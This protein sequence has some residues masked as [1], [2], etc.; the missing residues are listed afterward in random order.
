[1]TR[2]TGIVVFPDF[3]ILDAAGPISA[4][5]LAGR[6]AGPAAYDLQLLST[7][8][9]SVRSSSGVIVVTAPF[10]EAGWDTLLVAGGSGVREAASCP[11]TLAFVRAARP[12]RIGSVCSGAYVLAE[13][14]LL[15]GRRATTHWSRGEDFRRRYPKLRVEVDAIFVRDGSVWTSA[16][17][18]AGID[19]ALAMIEDDLGEPTARRTA[20][21]LV[22]FHRRPGG[23]SQHSALLDLAPKSDRIARALAF[24]RSHLAEP[25][26]VERIA[27]AA[28]LSPRQFARL[29]AQET[30][31]TPAKAVEQ[32][33]VEAARV[34]VEA[35]R[36]SMDEIARLTG[37]SD[38]DR[39]RSAFLR[40]YGQ[41]PQ[42]LRRGAA[43][44]G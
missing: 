2:R 10:D 9:G 17:I 4:F 32:L 29:F 20:Q 16:G 28:G 19:L 34:E 1:M 21:E 22:V 39:M 18:S 31:R 8:G 42:A 24:A 5:E 13:A 26:P 23:Q 25:L 7:D 12:R 41:P 11:K 3:Q 36:R 30:G 43:I 33:R 14:G 40:A 6:T 38:T 27:E 37:F 44:G 35:R 15:D